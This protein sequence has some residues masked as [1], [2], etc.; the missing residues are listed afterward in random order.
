MKR[1]VVIGG[2]LSGLAAAW[3]LLEEA[4]A[5]SLELDLTLLERDPQTGGKIRSFRE[6]GYLWEGGP[7]G[8]LDN[9]PSTLAL[10]KRLGIDGRLLKS[11]DEARKRYIFTGGTLK[12]LPEDPVS[13][14]LSDLISIRGKLRLGAEFFLPQGDPAQDES[15]AAFVRRRLGDEALEKLID[16]MSA[17]IYAGDPNVMSLKS[18]F[19]KVAQIEQ[20]FGGL[21]KGMLGLQKMA[22]A[23][24][25]EGP[26]TAGPGGY[27]WSFDEGA[28]V[29]TDTLAERL[30]TERVRAGREARAL[31][32]SEKGWTV[33]TADDSIEGVDAVV[34]AT[35]AF[36]AAQLLA[37]FDASLGDLLFAIPYVPAAVVSLGYARGDIPRPVDGFGFLIPRAEGR[38][39]LGSRWDSATFSGRAPDECVLL[40]Q[41]VGGA[42]NP[43]L[44]GLEDEPLLAVVRE[45]MRLTLGI[46]VPPPFARVIRWPRAIPQ[47]T[48]GHAKRLEAIEAKLS[49]LGPLFL[50]GNA[51]YGIGINDCTGHAGVLAP[52]LA[53][54]LAKGD[55][56][57]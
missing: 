38:K 52:R 25:Q 9:K 20:Q 23:R 37:P 19:P 47:Y 13:F 32:R 21:L 51:Y 17:G 33:R 22:K 7:P 26:K 41:I 54:V 18:C 6:H 35:P 14:L 10:S 56:A 50:G 11:S 5:R 53:E 44:V 40:T 57:A 46:S 24:G 28:G 27:L 43:E 34:V 36:D 2:G 55:A 42:R 39:I 48:V 30:G 31:E 3:S 45:E 8:F 16:P 49:A 12:L 15:V 1:A 4:R 29:L